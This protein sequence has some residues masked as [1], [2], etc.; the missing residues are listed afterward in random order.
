MQQKSLAL[1]LPIR[2]IPEALLSYLTA[3]DLD[4]PILL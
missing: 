1:M 3:R 2:E 4:V